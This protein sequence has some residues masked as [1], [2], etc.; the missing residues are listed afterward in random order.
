MSLMSRPAGEPRRPA[1][2]HAAPLPE[3]IPGEPCDR[4]G[5]P[6]RHHVFVPFRRGRHGRPELGELYFCL[7]HYDRVFPGLL[8]RGLA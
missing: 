8:A 6:A 3:A 7:H 1:P 2:V 4:C 5:C